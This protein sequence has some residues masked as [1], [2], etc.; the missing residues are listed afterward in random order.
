V[1]SFRSVVIRAIRKQIIT[2]IS[3]KAVSLAIRK[4]QSYYFINRHGLQIRASLGTSKG[5]LLTGKYS[6]A[7]KSMHKK[8]R[9]RFQNRDFNYVSRN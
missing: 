8:S 2:K 9:L 6:Y 4:E 7:S 3:N 5:F 1:R